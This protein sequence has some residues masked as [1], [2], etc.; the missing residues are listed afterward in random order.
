MLTIHWLE[1]YLCVFMCNLAYSIEKGQWKCR[2]S[3]KQNKKKIKNNCA[4]WRKGKK[5]AMEMPKFRKTNKQTKTL[6]KKY[7]LHIALEKGDSNAK[8]QKNK[9]INKNPKKNNFAIWCN[10]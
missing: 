9:Q 3:E 7:N 8:I 6:K 5:R 10:A 4:I 1:F 2:N